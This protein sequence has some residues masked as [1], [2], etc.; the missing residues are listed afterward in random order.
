MTMETISGVDGCSWGWLAVT[1]ELPTGR[2][3]WGVHT[4]TKELFAKH[5]AEKVIAIDIPIGLPDRGA[6]MCDLKARQLLGTERGAAIFTAPTRPE[7]PAEA[8]DEAGTP[9]A[10]SG[11]K[12]RTW[13]AFRVL[14]R[15]MQVDAILR[16]MPALRESVHEMHPEVSFFFLGGGRPTRHN[17]D[18]EEGSMERANLLGSVFGKAVEDVLAARFYVQVGVEDVLDAF[19]ALWTAERIRNKA[20]L[21]LP[22]APPVDTAG[23]RMEIVA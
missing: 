5:R 2:I 23:L 7:L 13:H 4:S 8:A 12:K 14:R 16:R 10:N 9:P 18:T 1:K 11:G 15:V 22:P 21:T 17:K 19:A 6:R 20:H 3:S